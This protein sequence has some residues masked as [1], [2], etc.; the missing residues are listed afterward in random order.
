M[1]SEQEKT[2][3]T[4]KKK[5][6]REEAVKAASILF[7]LNTK[8]KDILEFAE[9]AGITFEQESTRT[10]EC[11]LNEW[12][13]FVHASIV[14][15]LSTKFS[16]DVMMDYLRCT[17]ELLQKVAG[18][19]DLSVETFIDDTF[20]GYLTLMVQN[21]QKECPSLFLQRVLGVKDITTLPS[22][23]VAFLAGMMAI[24]ICTLLDKMEEYEYTEE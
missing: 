14:Y 8:E 6:T 10:K 18:Y 19:D 24:T 3:T 4:P 7:E 1:T 21:K 22:E 23:R 2:D 13:G 11:V 5:L 20:A 9:K 15:A 17:H 12:Y 16:N